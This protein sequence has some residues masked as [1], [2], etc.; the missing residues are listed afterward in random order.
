MIPKFHK[1]PI[2]FRFIVASKKCSTTPLSSAIG[3]ALNE[4]RRQRKYYCAKMEK[5]DGINR[6]WVIESNEAVLNCI[7][8]LNSTKSARSVT[9]YDFS[10]LYTAL[11]HDEILQCVSEMIDDV[12]KYRKK[13]NLPALLA[14]YKSNKDNQIWSH[15]C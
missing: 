3:K 5:Y 15:A 9:T 13:K 14:V 10:N 6:Y 12:F 7:N 8:N 4:V 11:P 1:N 2:K